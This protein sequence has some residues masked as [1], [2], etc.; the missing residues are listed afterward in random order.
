MRGAPSVL[1]LCTDVDV[2]RVRGEVKPKAPPMD[3]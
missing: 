1:G 3:T 2:G